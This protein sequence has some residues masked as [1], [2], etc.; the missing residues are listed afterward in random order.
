VSVDHTL[1]P[2]P[3]DRDAAIA[4]GLQILDAARTATAQTFGDECVPLIAF[5][6]CADIFANVDQGTIPN[7]KLRRRVQSALGLLRD[8]FKDTAEALYAHGKMEREKVVVLAPTGVQFE[9][10]DS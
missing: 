8:T 9:R 1:K 5:G 10:T 7:E 4:A 3:D 2:D 6:M